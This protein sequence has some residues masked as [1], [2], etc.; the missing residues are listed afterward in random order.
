MAAITML[1][2]NLEMFGPLKYGNGN[3]TNFINYIATVVSRENVD[4][5]AMVE[6]KNSV[7]AAVASE[8]GAAVYALQ[9]G[10]ANPWRSVIIDSKKNSEAYIIMYRTDRNF[11]P[12]RITGTT[13][14]STATTVP[15][16]G[17]GNASTGGG[18]LNFPSRHTNRGGRG[19]FYATFKTLNTDTNHTFSVVSYHAMFGPY[20][21]DGVYRLPG[22][23]YLFHFND[24][25]KTALYASLISGDFNM[26][27]VSQ[28]AYYG[29][30]LA[31][32]SLQATN[33]GTSLKNDPGVSNDPAHFMAN[34]YDNIFQKI[35]GVGA[36]PVGRTI[37]LLRESAIVP[38]PA[39]TPPAAPPGAGYL[40]AVANLYDLTVV[41]AKLSYVGDP[42]LSV[43][44]IS[45]TTSWQFVREV[46]SNHFPVIVTT[47]I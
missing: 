47:T 9:G 45:M 29:N 33:S 18:P 24:T 1:H 46:I 27:F 17:L 30:M 36:V 4:I 12:V 2:W 42:I 13:V 40:S 5:F 34:A 6:V 8:T 26:D 35:P 10:A 44:P 31:L 39:L 7:A 20:T 23:N 43:P 16:N 28:A 21:G 37:N 15:D 14:T 22:L 11:L 19:S 32:P 25:A 41:N 3:K 38:T